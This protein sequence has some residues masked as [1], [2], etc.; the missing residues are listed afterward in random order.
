MSILA[1]PWQAERRRESSVA[2]NSTVSVTSPSPR[3]RRARATPLRCRPRGGHPRGHT[4]APLQQHHYDK[5]TSLYLSLN[6]AKGKGIGSLSHLLSAH[7]RVPLTPNGLIHQPEVCRCSA[8]TPARA[9]NPGLP[10]LPSQ[11]R[12]MNKATPE[13]TLY[14]GRSRTLVMGTG[15]HGQGLASTLQDSVHP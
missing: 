7:Q 5:D 4:P 3:E 12:L 11:A 15:S 9:T 10:G 6:A 8:R 14:P 13:R 2:A 1:R